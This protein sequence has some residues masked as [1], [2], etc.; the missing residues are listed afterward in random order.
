MPTHLQIGYGY[1]C[2]IVVGGIIAAETRWPAKL[3][4]FTIWCFK[5]KLAQLLLL[6]CHCSLLASLSSSA[7]YSPEQPVKAQTDHLFKSLFYF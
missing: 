5:K 6:G 4:I 1:F 7:L 2:T 3:Q